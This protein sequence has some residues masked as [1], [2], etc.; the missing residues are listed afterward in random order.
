MRLTPSAGNSS[1]LAR[2][3]RYEEGAWWHGTLL[4]GQLN[5]EGLAS[6]TSS[7]PGTRFRH[8]GFGCRR[9]TTRMPRSNCRS[10]LIS[11]SKHSLGPPLTLSLEM[12]PQLFSRTTDGSMVTRHQTYHLT[13]W[14]TYQHEL[15]HGSQFSKDCRIG[16]GPGHAQA[17]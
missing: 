7:W 14:A 10:R 16:I 5:L 3:N 1:G 2:T 6:M 8:A 13:W 11:R 17:R 4:A 9:Q 15:E 12:E